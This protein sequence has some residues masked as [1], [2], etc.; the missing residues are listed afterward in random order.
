MT[1]QSTS[2]VKI[3]EATIQNEIRQTVDARELWT[4]LE[5]KQDF[6]DWIKNRIE[7]YGFVEGNEFSIKLWKNSKRGRPTTE[8]TITLDMAKELAMVERNEKGKQ[9]RRYFIECEKKYKETTQQQNAK[10]EVR[11]IA[12]KAK[13]LTKAAPQYLSR[14]EATIEALQEYHALSAHDRMWRHGGVYVACKACGNEYE[15]SP[16][17]PLKGICKNCIDI[18]ATRPYENTGAMIANA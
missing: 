15:T 9:A 8:Y 10:H 3:K 17:H 18:T 2:L 12:Q 14:K 6:S 11:Q 4:F 1:T 7:E 13:L 16:W 5:S